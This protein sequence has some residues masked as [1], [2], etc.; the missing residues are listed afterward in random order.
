MSIHTKLVIFRNW[1]RIILFF[2][3][4]LS[5]TF[6]IKKFILVVKWSSGL[7]INNVAVFNFLYRN[8]FWDRSFFTDQMNVLINC[9]KSVGI[10]FWWG[11]KHGHRVNKQGSHTIF[12][13]FYYRDLTLKIKYKEKYNKWSKHEVVKICDT[14]RFT[15]SYSNVLF[16]FQ[17]WALR[18]KISKCFI[19]NK[20]CYEKHLV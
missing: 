10:A 13:A 14:T 1:E 9:M 4:L 2:W 11:Q 8:L 6:Q 20:I 19:V 7:L 17:K 16:I 12:P 15:L 18:A 3:C 5:L